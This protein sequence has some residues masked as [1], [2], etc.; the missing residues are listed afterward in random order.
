MLFPARPAQPISR[1]NA[2]PDSS[3]KPVNRRASTQSKAFFHSF[4]ISKSSPP[5]VRQHPKPAKNVLFRLFRRI[6]KRAA[7]TRFSSRAR[8]ESRALSG[9]S[10]VKMLLSKVKKKWKARRTT[11]EKCR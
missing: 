1:L 3:S 7:Q 8:R 2:A 10:F 6:Q 5:R 11:H 4:Q 9:N